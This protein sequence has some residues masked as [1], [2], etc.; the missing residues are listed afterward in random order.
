MPKRYWLLKSEPED[1][2]FAKL[3]KDGRVGWTGV[4]NYQARNSMRDDMKIGDGVLFYHSNANPSAIV[5]IAEV[6]RESHSD[7]T[8][9][10]KSSDYYDPKAK[11]E[12]PTW[13]MV[14]IK[15]VEELK[16]PLSLEELRA[17]PGLEKMLLLKRGMRLSVQPVTPEEWKIICD[18]GCR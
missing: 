17:T 7:P 12:T 11:R 6:S 1:Y 10:E 13:L 2:P 5:G 8:Q 15:Y 4:R 14:E 3:K 16:R 9:F 18:A